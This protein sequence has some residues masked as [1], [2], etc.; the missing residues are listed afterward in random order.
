MP[1]APCLAP[2]LAE[3][4]VNRVRKQGTGALGGA[5]AGTAPW[6]GGAKVP[7]CRVWGLG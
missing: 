7:E 3:N 1:W 6:S 5:L 2:A 4:N